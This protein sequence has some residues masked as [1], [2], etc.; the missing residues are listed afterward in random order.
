MTAPAVATTYV[1]ALPA[2]M[3]LLNANDTL[4][5]R[6]KA[7]L[8]ESIG[9]AAIVLTRAAKVPRLD[10]VTIRAVLHPHDNRR[11]DPHN[12]YPSIKAAIDGIVRAGALPDD[13][14]KHLLSVEV[15]LGD[16]VKRGQLVLHIT[17]VTDP[18]D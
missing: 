12:W 4:H 3:K 7:D 11:R 1:V 10:R 6:A 15:V 8:I 13:D 14:A 9:D 2:G 16:P 18:K 17:P 5:W